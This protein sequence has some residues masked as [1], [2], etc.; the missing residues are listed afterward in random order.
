LLAD[1]RSCTETLTI[2]LLR[3]FHCCRYQRSRDRTFHSR[4]VSRTAS[5]AI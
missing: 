2:N 1:F 5:G 3:T 4:A